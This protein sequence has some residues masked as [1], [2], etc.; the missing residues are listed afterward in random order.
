MRTL[1]LLLGIAVLTACGC[2][3]STPPPPPAKP[4]SGY[5]FEVHGAGGSTKGQSLDF[6]IQR[7]E[8]SV[9]MKG[10]RLAA[11][12]KDYGAVTDGAAI[13]VEESGRVLVNGKEL[14]PK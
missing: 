2:G 5:T 7:N 13:V 4:P 3:P 14:T 9:E 10:G 6:R 12:G 11:N 8:T 1:A